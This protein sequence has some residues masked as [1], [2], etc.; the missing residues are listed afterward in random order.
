MKK[1]IL[2]LAFLALTSNVAYCDEGEPELQNASTETL[3]EFLEYCK[4]NAVEDD[5][6]AAEMKKYLLVCINE[7]LE[8]SYYNTI[9]AL[10][11]G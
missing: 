5:I 4:D 3:M 1:I 10:P 2:S 9:T 6:S 11:M 8:E 7:E